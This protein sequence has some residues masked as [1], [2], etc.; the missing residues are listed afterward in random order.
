MDEENSAD[1]F[2]NSSSEPAEEDHTQKQL[3]EILDRVGYME[4]VLRDQL[5]RL[6]E[7]EMRMGITPQGFKPQPMRQPQ[8]P[9]QQVAKPSAPPTQSPRPEPAA[10]PNQVRPSESQGIGPASPTSPAMPRST[11]EQESRPAQA[12]QAPPTAQ[13][14]PTFG[15][16]GRT[17]SQTPTFRQPVFPPPEPPKNRDDLEFRIGGV[18]FNII[19]VIVIVFAVGFFLKLAFDSGWITPTYQVWTG[20]FIGIT[21]LGLGEWLRK[22]YAGYAYSLTGGGILILYLSTWASFKI[23]DPVIFSQQMAFVLMALITATASILAARYNTLTIAI[24]GLFGGF[25]TPILL[26]TEVD[27]E[28]ALFGY[29]A[30]LNLGVLSLAFTKQWRSLNY[31][32]F[33]AT[34]I[35]VLSWIIKWYGSTKLWTTII[36]LTLFFVIFA[37]LAVLYN[38]VNRRPTTWLDLTL[39]FLNAILYFSATYSLLSAS[40]HAGRYH[41]YLG[42]FAVLMACF[43]G[44]LGY[45]TYSRDREDRLLILTF[46]GLAC[47]FLVLAVPIQFDQQWVT[48]AW[49]IEGAIMTFIGLR[50]K[51]KTSLYAALV[52][53]GI[54]AFHWFAI[55]LPQFGYQAGKTFT[56]V[57]NNRGLSC[58]VLVASLAAASLFYKRLG[59]HLQDE[60]RSMFGGLYLLGANVFAITLLSFDVHNY[61]EQKKAATDVALTDDVQRLG[62]TQLF[63]LTALW[64][65]YS[66]AALMIGVTRKLQLLRIAALALLAITALKVFATDFFF[67]DARWHHTIFNQTFASFAALIAALLCGIWLYSRSEGI[68][69]TERAIVLPA[70]IG[71]ANLLAVFSLSIEVIGHYNRAAAS[72]T[73]HLDESKQFALSV[74]WM[75]YGAAALL[76]GIIRNSKLLRGGGMILFILTI[77]KLFVVDLTYFNSAWHRLVV[78]QTFGA[79][80]LMVAALAMTVWFYVRSEAVELEE[81][82]GVVPFLIVIANVLSL[83]ALSAEAWGYFDKLISAGNLDNAVDFDYLHFRDWRLAQQLSLSV[84]W[85]LYGGAM[86]TIGI[87]RRSRLLRIMALL[88]LSLTILKVFFLDLAS[89]EKLYRIVS[90]IV[91]GLIL[92]AVSFLYQRFRFLF[93]GVK[94]EAKEPPKMPANRS[95]S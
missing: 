78:N 32:S 4:R 77:C 7:I 67:Y 44:L 81:R 94:D 47:L 37:L 36:F 73:S 12:N 21:C 41:A 69:E 91:L 61:F 24:L 87:L 25:L 57:W 53:F 54:A 30:L 22:K 65:M 66:A 2:D 14:V 33:A 82:F 89:L 70:L 58:A 55:D 95:E 5:S 92:L 16:Q 80:A 27:N 6:Y 26:S 35:M 60:E 11:V 23:Y 68:D 48:M 38:V 15:A 39:V 40:E 56:P 31:L 64:A 42:G 93:G 3:Q 90:F 62:N 52:V 50:V 86:L 88:L 43:Y 49:A 83:V 17:T 19:G 28:T 84:I 34:V 13:R 74:L 8:R 72:A 18:W 76:F 1:T 9:P 79:F 63:A 20:I 46:Y 29:I 75:V 85:A 51:D 71:A 45:F 59:S 10:Q